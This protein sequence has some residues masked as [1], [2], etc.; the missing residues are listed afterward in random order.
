MFNRRFTAVGAIVFFFAIGTVG[1]AGSPMVRVQP[2][3][4]LDESGLGI[5]VH[6][7]LD[8]GDGGTIFGGLAVGAR[9]GDFAD[10]NVDGIAD[11]GRH[12]QEVFIPGPFVPGDAVASASL[13]C[14]AGL[15][16]EAQDLGRPISIAEP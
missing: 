9:Q 13:S 12:E 7:I 16:L 5:V 1:F 10:G 11:E 6:V 4:E 8:C 14:G 15:L 3:A 2:H